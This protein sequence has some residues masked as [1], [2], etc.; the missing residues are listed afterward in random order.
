MQKKGR[1]RRRLFGDGKKEKAS[2][3]GTFKGVGLGLIQGPDHHQK[4]HRAL[5]TCSR[6]N[7]SRA[8]RCEVKHAARRGRA[9]RGAFV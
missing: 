7:L 4:N 1:R 9:E 8:A 2:L 6:R 3:A 5:S